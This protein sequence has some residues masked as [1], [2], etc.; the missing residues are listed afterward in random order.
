MVKSVRWMVTPPLL[1]SMVLILC[2]VIIYQTRG[3]FSWF[4]DKLE[5]IN[6]IKTN[7]DY[8]PL[9]LVT[10]AYRMYGYAANLMV[11]DKEASR[12]WF[13]MH[14]REFYA[15]LMINYYLYPEQHLCMAASTQK[16]Y[17]D[18]RLFGVETAIHHRPPKNYEKII[19]V[20]FFRAEFTEKEL[21]ED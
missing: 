9:M 17:M 3:N 16:E 10:D 7:S 18:D 15:P 1:I 19:S 2:G 5:T 6:E 13:V 20:S 14:N 12:Y 8:H 11:T 4:Q 21:V